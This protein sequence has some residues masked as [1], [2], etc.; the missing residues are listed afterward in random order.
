M[1]DLNNIFK[2]ATKIAYAQFYTG[3]SC[4]ISV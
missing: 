3:R 2:Q 4:T 1:Q